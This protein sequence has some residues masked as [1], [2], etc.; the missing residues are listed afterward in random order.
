M[1]GR[2]NL[3]LMAKIVFST[4]LLCFQVKGQVRSIPVPTIPIVVGSTKIL[5]PTPADFAIVTPTMSRAYELGELLV[6]ESNIQ[7]AF[8]IPQSQIEVVLDGQSGDY[9]R[10]FR[11]QTSKKLNTLP[12]PPSKLFAPLKKQFAN[13][14]EATNKLLLDRL[15]NISRQLKEK[16]DSLV[17]SF[18]YNPELSVS[19]MVIVPGSQET[20]NSY[21]Y[22]MYSRAS[23]TG[24]DGKVTSRLVSA[25]AAFILVKGQILFLYAYGGEKDLEWTRTMS[26]QWAKSILSLNTPTPHKQNQGAVPLHS[27]QRR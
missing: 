21:D 2:T 24:E 14:N 16:S 20:E 18:K 19:K 25:T 11:V 26:R 7:F 10:N 27:P 23:S 15:P 1:R 13:N 9:T 17:E 8:F 3:N 6:P 4:F 12:Y 5:I 22:S